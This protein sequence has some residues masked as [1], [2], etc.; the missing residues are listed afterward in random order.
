MY[1]FESTGS[2]K[3]LHTMV[4]ASFVAGICFFTISKQAGIP[5]PVIFQVIAVICLMAG[6][7]L[8]TRYSLRIYRYAVEPSGIVDSDGVEQYDLLITDI[9]GKKMRPVLRVALRD[10]VEIKTVC[11]A[12]KKIY[13]AV[14]NAYG[15][16]RKIFRYAN[17][18]IL[19]EECHITVREDRIMITI[20]IPKDDRMTAILTSSL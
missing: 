2:R 11:R 18:P 17:T 9:V 8:T 4:I 6:V 1:A 7:Y 19:S 14:M 12:D 13:R 20:I 16:D 10:V 3:A 15:K 5:F